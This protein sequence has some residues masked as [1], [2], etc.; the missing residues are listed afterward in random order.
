M[1][2]IYRQIQ[3]MSLS[4]RNKTLASLEQSNFDLIIIGGGITGAGIALDAILRGVSVLLVEKKDFGSG[5]S[6][7]STKLIHGGLRYLKQLE[8]G[9]VRETGVERAIAHNNIP[10]LVHPEKMLLPI[11]PDGEFN[12]W[13]ASIAIS[14][15]DRL[16]SVKKKDRKQSYDRRETLEI[17]PL[18]R[19]E[20]L[21][22]SIQ[23]S[24]YRTDDARLTMELIKAAQRHGAEAF[25]YVECTGLLYED[26][27]VNGI[28][29]MD[30]IH[31]KTYSFYGRNIVS[32]A[33]PWVDGIREKDGSLE[34]KKLHLTKGVHLVVPHEKLP[35]RSAVYFDD[36]EGRMLFAIPRW[37]ATY[38]GTT[39]TNYTGSL[40]QVSTNQEDADY[41]LEAANRIF[42][43]EPLGYSDIISH[44]AGL[45]PL[46]HEASKGPTEISRKDE[47]F[48][49]DSGLISIAGGK[50]TGFRKM[51]KRIVDLVRKRDP[52]LRMGACETRYFPIH[53][54]H[55]DSYEDY[56]EFRETMFELKKN[57]AQLNRRQVYQLCDTFGKSADR[58]I[59]RAISLDGHPIENLLT[60]ELEHCS[61]KESI[62]CVDDYVNRRTS[63]LYFDIQTVIDHQDHI[64]REMHRLLEWT[65][66][67]FEENRITLEN[68][69]ADAQKFKLAI[70]PV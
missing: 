68:I 3:D 20:A 13:S 70:S 1:L 64:L 38:I 59:E 5:T 37:S 62:V 29:A 34:G 42:D 36:F 16:A 31:S 43:I 32:A 40:D 23:Y 49:A 65:D 7:K 30:T 66:S 61:E 11:F 52:Q 56:Q 2:D 48:I 19:S 55:I 27:Q 54:E 18:L 8:F 10:H 51:A 50:L 21:Q 35:I 9:L 22:S 28:S 39:D 12:H 46:V 33:G 63:R 69:L 17:E 45:R 4:I 15:Y 67:Q 25:N 60:A 14:V 26:G 44:W 57:K 6:S 24:E 58:I 41:V 53:E 47:I